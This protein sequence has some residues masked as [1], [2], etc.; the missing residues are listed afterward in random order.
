MR[1]RPGLESA[2][3]LAS[4]GALLLPAAAAA[5]ALT[6][7]A[8][9]WWLAGAARQERIVVGSGMVLA[10]VLLLASAVLPGMADAPPEAWREEVRRGVSVLWDELAVTAERAAEQLAPEQTPPLELFRALEVLV[11]DS[12]LTILLVNPHGDAVAWAGDGL[13]HELGAGE[14]PAAGFA[15]RQGFTAATLF[16]VAPSAGSRGRW[17]VVVGRSLA[18]DRLP[19][20]IAVRPRPEAVSW[21]LADA[22][23]PPPGF[24]G[25]FE[26]PHEGAPTVWVRAELAAD[27]RQAELAGAARRVAFGLLGLALLALILLRG[28]GRRLL[29]GDPSGGD[30]AGLP[31]LAMASAAAAA[32]AA[33]LETPLTL[34]LVAAV[35]LTAGGLTWPRR[36]SVRNGGGEWIGA[37][38]WP[39]L[40]IAAWLYQ[41]AFGGVD[42][43]SGL[44]GDLEMLALRLLGCLAAL[45]VLVLAAR[46]RGPALGDRSIWIAAALVLAGA[47]L[48]D[49][50]V[51][52]LVVLALAGAAA[53]R[54]LTGVDLAV[55][56]MAAGGLLL[57]AALAGAVGWEI[58]Y[59]QVFRQ[60]L[61]RRYLPRVAPPT[62]DEL[63]DMHSEV[64]GFF[65]GMDLLATLPVAAGEELDPQDLAFALW[66]ASPLPRRDGL[67]ALVVEAADG[68]RSSFSFGL[69]LDDQLH[70]ISNR[71]DWSVPPVPAWQDSLFEGVAELRLGGRPWGTATYWFLPRPGFRLEIDEI[72]E[73]ESALLRGRP[74]RRAVDGLPRPALYG[75]YSETGQ[76]LVS[77]WAEAPPLDLAAVSAGAGTATVETP[78]GA[79]WLCSRRAEHGI[80][81]LYLPLL[82]PRDGLERVGVHTLSTLACFAVIA[83]LVL[84]FA[85][86]RQAFRDLLRRTLRS[87][88]KRLILVYA[89]LLLIPLIALNLVLLRGFQE[90]LRGEQI[91]IARAATASARLVLLRHLDSLEPGFVLETRINRS[92]LEWVS[93][94]VQHQVTVYWGSRLLASSQQ[95][96]F[97]AA[98]LPRRIP[99]D[100]FARLELLGYDVDSRTQSGGEQTYLELYAP[101]EIP[102]MADS[103]KGLF[104]SVPLLE[105]EEEVA[106]E[107]ADMRRRAMLVTSALVLLL[108]A[109]GSRLTRSFT[110]PILQLIEGTRRIA[111]GAPF[112]EVTPREQELSSLADAIDSMAR[113]IA[114]GRR[115]LLREKSLVE[116]IV[117]NITSAVVSLDRRHRVL[118]H[119]R[120]AAELLGTEVG[121]QLERCL[122]RRPR[123]ERLLEFLAGVDDEHR[124]T[125]TL[126][127]G[128]GDGDPREWTL[129][130]LPIPGGEDPAA[131]LVIDDDT[132]VLRGQRLEAWAEMARIIAHEIKNPLTPIRLS[133]EH[134]RE[135]YAGDRPRFEAVFERCTG[136]ILQQVEELR[137]IASDFSIYSR[138]PRAELAEDDLA[139]ALREL[140]E[141]YRAAGPGGER[142]VMSGGEE[143]IRTRFD[144]KLLGRAVRNLLEN[145]LR[146]SG[147]DGRVELSLAQ[148]G[149][150]AAIRVVDSGPGVESETL[151]RIFDPYFSTYDS[152]T[153]LGLAITRRIVEE[154]GGRIE[155]HNHPNGGLEVTITLPLSPPSPAP[156]GIE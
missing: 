85:L 56:P 58:A 48:H 117:D 50:P 123:L 104:L 52:A 99:G 121:E 133:T 12:G 83:V 44:G 13:L 3:F 15:Y 46:R 33:D 76:A 57:I 9:L 141:G 27:H 8:V 127:L 112:L 94:V 155:A 84:L 147:E 151:Q 4:V 122:E 129:I 125:A 54:W 100:V 29:A 120:V 139:A 137:D 80:E 30:P 102:D 93:G 53:V 113:R 63:A 36:P 51:P 148:D 89:G 95:E 144:S 31:I 43:A 62:A 130:W 45:A 47:A 37:L 19:F 26:V 114:E 109:V 21:T 18:T 88:S 82:T 11:A 49:A 22:S 59:R 5:A 78:A 150:R 10:A 24:L 67:S 103:A 135:V 118:L 66:R 156:D 38:G 154:H 152:G 143:A 20:E 14:L 35:G 60:Q 145:A 146:A 138:I 79:A 86:P 17:R 77:P 153:G 90:R 65:D 64:F 16:A 75:L 115:Q 61:E 7:L 131:L 40:A 55:R 107:L 149:G 101:L 34:G 98:L 119:N 126:R 23:A 106:R 32:M 72:S 70:L 73:L 42:L 142:I 71:D 87:Y 92:F 110:T 2:V 132:E 69:A 136:N 105:E 134:M 41:D 81:V 74:H 111:G 124:R 97:T 6:A 116:R 25:A 1:L 140:V 68:R 39:G 96:L 128:G 91:A 108:L 28:A